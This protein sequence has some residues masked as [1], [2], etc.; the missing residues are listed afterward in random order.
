ME[1]YTSL[2]QIVVV[3]AAVVQ[4]CHDRHV[5]Q[6]SVTWQFAKFSCTPFHIFDIGGLYGA[7]NWHQITHA[8]LSRYDE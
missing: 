1:N 6:A 4:R 5:H 8:K 2:M 7:E 3:Q